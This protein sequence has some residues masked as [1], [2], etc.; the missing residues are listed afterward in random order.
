[1]SAT[2]K[3]VAASP[4]DHYVGRDHLTDRQFRAGDRF[5][6]D[7]FRAG[8]VP[9]LARRLGAPIDGGPAGLTPS[10][11]QIA[12][13]QRWRRAITAVGQRLSPVL[14]AVCCEERTAAQWSNRQGRGGEIEG[15]TTLRL[16]LDTLGDHYGL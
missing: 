12:A 16:A 7:Y 9:P 4:L 14:I 5:R 10:E 6:A 11:R 1:M 2:A 8:L 15:M 13:R 3:R